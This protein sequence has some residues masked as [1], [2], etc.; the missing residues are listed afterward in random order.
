MGRFDHEKRAQSWWGSSG[1]VKPQKIGSPK[2]AKQRLCPKCHCNPCKQRF[3][4]R[5]QN[6]ATGKTGKCAVV[7]AFLL[8][9]LIS[10]LYGVFETV[11]WMIWG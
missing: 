5:R 4:C 6:Q 3:E 8:S 9:G 1:K 7:A 10:A 11:Q 2:K